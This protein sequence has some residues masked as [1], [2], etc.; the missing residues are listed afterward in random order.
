MNG[1][2]L[3]L[4]TF[5][6]E[7]PSQI[8]LKDEPTFAHLT[9]LLDFFF[10]FSTSARPK[11]AEKSGFVLSIE[12]QI[13]VDDPEEEA[14]SVES[15]DESR[16]HPLEPTYKVDLLDSIGRNSDAAWVGFF[17]TTGESL[18][19][20]SPLGAQIVIECDAFEWLAGLL[21]IDKVTIG[22][23]NGKFLDSVLLMEWNCS[24]YS[25]V[26]VLTYDFPLALT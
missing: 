8:T 14:A 2:T 20:K 5:S 10:F 12:P 17:A 18:W 4:E 15:N 21:E 3:S 1:E 22:K 26:C 25:C 23:S 9:D 24:L 11:A 6:S 16:A 19:T 7:P 13:V